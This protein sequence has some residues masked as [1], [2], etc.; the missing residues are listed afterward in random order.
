MKYITRTFSLALLLVLA[1]G[2][3]WLV[4]ARLQEEG[5]PR[6]RNEGP[7][8]VPVEVAEIERGSIELRRTFSGALEATAEFVVAPKVGG[9]VE[10]LSVDLADRVDRGQNVAQLDNA[11]YIQSVAQAKADL[12]VARA[13]RSEAGS[14]LEIAE[15]KLERIRT[16]RKRGVA[17]ESQ[18]DTAKAEQLAA[19]SGLA[20]AAAQVTRAEASLEAARIR[21]G[22]TSV[23]ADWTGG[24][25][26]R[27]VAERFV[28]EGNTVSAN[29][30]LMSIVELDPITGVIFVTE[31]D[32]ARIEP[33]Q[34]A[35]LATDAFP[36]EQFAGRVSRIAPV[37]KEA[38]RQARVELIVE[39]PGHLLKP[40]MFIRVSLMLDQ[41]REALIVPE[42]ALTRRNDRD[43]VFVIDEETMTVAWREVVTGIQGQ[44]RVQIKSP[45]LSGRVV[46]L[47]QQMLDHGAPVSIPAEL[48][49][50]ASLSGE[51][52]KR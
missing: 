28:D 2:L 9:R 5:K 33:G 24:D 41:A 12:A 7:R 17:S 32:Y 3:V 8:A 37:F 16:L 19:K 30:P 22:Y 51:A 46:T 39:N 35:R 31:R 47:G 26:Q 40:G 52:G 20:V 25:D 48:G 11:E 6:E 34:K 43:G 27:L 21:L 13:N 4:V 29:T 10:R 18:L 1:A 36:D 42:T 15:R 49:S 23:S 44:D 14:A 45:E 38:T 50:E